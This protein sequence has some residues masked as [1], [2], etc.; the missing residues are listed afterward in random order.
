MNR[1]IGYARTNGPLTRAHLT[2]PVKT[3]ANRKSRN[4]NMMQD[5]HT[6]TVMEWNDIAAEVILMTTAPSALI[7]FVAG[8]GEFVTP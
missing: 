4:T 8:T 5:T 6:H 1:I 7:M 3:H 2:V